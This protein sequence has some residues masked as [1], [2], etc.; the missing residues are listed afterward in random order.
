MNKK[1]MIPRN[2]RIG[3][4]NEIWANIL[5]FS[6]VIFISLKDLYANM[7]AAINKI[8]LINSINLDIIK[9]E[10]NEINDI[11]VFYSY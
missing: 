11:L 4:H 3:I 9:L 7:G 8:I 2:M 1:I 5:L 6:L 10:I